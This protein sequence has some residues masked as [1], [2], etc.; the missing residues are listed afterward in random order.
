MNERGFLS[1]RATREV[2]LFADDKFEFKNPFMEKMDYHL[3]YNALNL[4]DNQFGDLIPDP[5]KTN[6]RESIDAIIFDSDIEAAE[7]KITELMVLAINVP[8]LDDAKEARL[9]GSLLNFVISLLIFLLERR[10]Q[11]AG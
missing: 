11:L 6:I 5:Y 8:W 9:F 2:A 1:Q 3:F 10:K 4:L 7:V